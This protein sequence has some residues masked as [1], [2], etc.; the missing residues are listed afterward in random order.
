MKKKQLSI[1]LFCCLAVLIPLAG[2]CQEPAGGEL[3][4]VSSPLANVHEGSESRSR[5]ETQV[6]MGD[7]VRVLAKE[8]NRYRVTI[9]GQDNREGWIQQEAVYIPKD[10]GRSYMNANR[11]WIVITAPKAEAMILDKTGD[12]KVSLYAGTRLQVLQTTDKGHKVQFPD[13]SV[14]IIDVAEAMP[15]KSSD[16]VI[17]DTKPEDIARTAKQFLNVR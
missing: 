11:Q 15:V 13:K 1:L 16:P 5:L 3:G 17:N 10:K 2:I 9:P 6:L 4:I 14:A 7:E 8:D 12:H